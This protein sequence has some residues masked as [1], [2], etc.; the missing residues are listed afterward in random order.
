MNKIRIL[1]IALVLI[2]FIV[3]LMV[4]TGINVPFEPEIDRISE[5]QITRISGSG[6]IYSD[7]NPMKAENMSQLNMVDIREMQH[8]D[9]MY[10][11]AD[12]QTSLEFY[13]FGTSF[14]ALP[15]S[16]IYYQPKTKE[17]SLYNGEYYWKREIK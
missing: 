11:K 15:G 17:L 5:F 9:E 1:F 10:I 8:S 2:V 6:A 7:K 4:F 14:T 16:Y 3:S 12:A 13:F